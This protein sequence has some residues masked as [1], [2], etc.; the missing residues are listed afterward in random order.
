MTNW[1]DIHSAIALLGLV[2]Y[3]LDSHTRRKRRHPSAAI[4]WFI[5]L[6]LLP[7]VAF[8]L[9]LFFGRRKVELAEYQH[10]KYTHAKDSKQSEINI[11]S[12]EKLARA[13]GLG[14][15][16]KFNNLNIHKDGAQALQ[17][18]EACIANANKTLDIC[19]FIFGRDEKGYQISQLLAECAQR[20]VKVRLLIDGFGYYLDGLVSFKLLKQAGVEVAFFA[21]PFKFSLLGRTNMRNHR[22]LVIADRSHLWSGG[23][24]LSHKYFQDTASTKKKQWVDLTFNFDGALAQQATIVFEQD[25]AF[26][27][28]KAIPKKHN[29]A[30]HLSAQQTLGARLVPSGPDRSEDTIY[31][32]LIS[33]CYTAQDHILIATPYFVPDPTLLTALEL[34]CHRGVRVNLLVPETSNHVLADIARRFA[35][36]DLAQA[37]A[38]IWLSPSMLHAKAFIFDDTLAL[39]G[40]ANLDERSLFLNYE[41]MVAFYESRVIQDFSSWIYRQQHAASLY[42]P[43]RAGMWRELAEGLVRWV[44][45]QL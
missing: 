24:N 2:I 16:V 9:Y 30:T 6:L 13:L 12:D 36:R 17:A 39:V 3:A 11:S 7:Y 41:L 10:K 1:F 42:K 33:G 34:A 26:A 31:T 35:L 29:T 19:T 20:G 14:P 22:K 21:P 27:T 45:F 25:W 40:S 8:P 32:M 4:A 38:N 37:G 18:L 28:Q 44:A 43:R 23:R 5:S 15:S